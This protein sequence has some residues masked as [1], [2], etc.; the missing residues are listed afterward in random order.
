MAGDYGVSLLG[1]YGDD[2][3]LPE[4]NR[5]LVPLI[6]KLIKL[7]E[8][9]GHIAPGGAPPMMMQPGMRVDPSAAY[10]GGVTYATSV[11]QG[12]LGML[13]TK[14]YILDI[15]AY[16]CTYLNLVAIQTREFDLISESLTTT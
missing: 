5:E 3:P 6:Q 2:I 1:I 10:P 8:E 7:L 14:D 12:G 13:E 9:G 11:Q 16:M 15:T 4:T